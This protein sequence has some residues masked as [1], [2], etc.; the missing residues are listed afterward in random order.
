MQRLCPGMHLANS[1]LLLTFAHILASLD[2][3][4]ARDIDGKII[5]LNVS[6]KKDTSRYVLC[7]TRKTGC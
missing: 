3:E 6:L 1:H 2:L 4:K 7:C 5:E